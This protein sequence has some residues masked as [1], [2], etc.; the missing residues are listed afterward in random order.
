VEPIRAYWW[1]EV[2]NLGDVLGPMVLRSLGFEVIWTGSHYAEWIVGGSVL[3]RFPDRPVTVWGSGR[4]SLS[5]PKPDLSQARVL[6][7][8]GDL[9]ARNVSGLDHDPALGDP[10]LLADRLVKRSRTPDRAEVIVPHWSDGT[11]ARLYPDHPVVDVTGDPMM[12]LQQIADASGVIASSLHG[13]V[14]ADAFGL[15][16]RWE[17][18]S[19]CI[20][21]FKFY[22]YASTVG[23]IEPERWAVA[24]PNRVAT[25][26]AVLYDVLMEATARAG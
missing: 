4:F 5:R 13:I 26:K 20:P 23:S 1:N 15:P 19:A 25:V 11:M 12:A 10:G 3:E 7:L 16:R 9:T 22:D 14:L 6:A 2:P 17:P 24:D 18:C 8:R 21:P